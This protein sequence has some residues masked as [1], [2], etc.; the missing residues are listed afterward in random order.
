MKASTPESQIKESLIRLNSGIKVADGATISEALTELDRLLAEH[1]ATLDP[2]LAH[3][4]EG[5]SYAKAMAWLGTAS[6][7]GQPGSPPGGC[8]Q[9]R[10]GQKPRA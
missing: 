10:E 4:L 6:D 5:R 8:G 1:R 2:R 9:G 3:F 7:F